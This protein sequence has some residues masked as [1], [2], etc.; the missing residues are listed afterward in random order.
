MLISLRGI[1]IVNLNV[2]LITTLIIIAKYYTLNCKKHIFHILAKDCCKR[3]FVGR[4]KAKP[5]MCD[6]D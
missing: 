2:E 4:M 1:N 3:G 6:Y 5:Q